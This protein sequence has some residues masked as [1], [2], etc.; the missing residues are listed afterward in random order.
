[1]R[2]LGALGLVG[3][4]LV[5]LG[6]AAEAQAPY[7][8]IIAFGDS[9]TRGDKRF[10]EQNRGGYPGRLQGKLRRDNPDAEVLNF[11]RDSETTG[12]GL[13]RLGFALAQAPGADALLLMEGTND[14]SLVVQGVLSFESIEANLAN[15]VTQA[16]N[17]GLAV[18][19]S[20]LI[21]R[22]PW[23]RR[24]KNNILTF[25]M[26]RVVRDLAYRKQSQSA[27]PWEE[28]F[29]TPRV[30]STL[31]SR[32]QDDTV[33]H[34]NAAGFDV[35]SDLFYDLVSGLD[36]K[37]PVP[38]D[39]EPGYDVSTIGPGRDIS[40]TIYDLG[41]GIDPA[42]TTLTINDIAVATTQD[43]NSRRRTLFHDTTAETLACYAR[44]GIRSA[45]LAD[46]PN[47]TDRVYKEF[48]V[49]NGSILRG[50]VNRSC[51]VDGVDLVLF[52]QAFGARSGDPRYLATADIDKNGVIDGVDFAFLA[53]NFG[54]SSS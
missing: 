7:S 39:L 53:S 48:Q 34:P 26:A 43:G 24:D 51:R 27:D 38:G 12:Q 11:G 19:P 44:V 42:N 13:S 52:A 40:L 37:G 18:F 16:T 9:I 2:P 33:G 49:Q 3:L 4:V 32:A 1:M 21:P 14:I 10:D 28:L 25:A 50:D 35:L 41:A 29:H 5:A 45:D 46:P 15:M 30:F 23:A 20:T 54:R 36:T 47:V 17:A 8:R 22:P 6:S 31:Y